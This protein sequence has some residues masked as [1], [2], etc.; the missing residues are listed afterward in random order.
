LEL[1]PEATLCRKRAHRREPV[2][3]T[4]SAFLNF[5]EFRSDYFNSIHPHR[6][7]IATKKIPIRRK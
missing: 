4:G 1:L 5:F 3:E 2:A 7:Q 6:I